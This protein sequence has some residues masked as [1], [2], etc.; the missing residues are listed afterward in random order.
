[1]ALQTAIIYIPALSGIFKTV[2]LSVPQ[3]LAVAGAAAR[4]VIVMDVTKLAGVRLTDR[5]GGSRR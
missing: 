5:S 4:A 3:W 1:M 2:P